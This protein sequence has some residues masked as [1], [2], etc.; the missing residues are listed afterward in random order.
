MSGHTHSL[1]DT[2]EKR[3]RTALILTLGAMGASIGG[4]ILSHSLALLSDAGLMLADAGALALALMAQRVASR[5]RTDLRT[6]GSRRAETPAA[7]VNAILLGGASG[8]GVIEA[9]G[10]GAETPEIRRR[11]MLP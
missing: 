9:A 2:P 7:F 10:R 8:L 11:V 3:I 5:P 6:Y 1:H 4:G